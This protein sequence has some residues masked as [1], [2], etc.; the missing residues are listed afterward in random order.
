MAFT[1]N[2]GQD[3]LQPVNHQIRRV[4]AILAL[5][6]YVHEG[7]QPSSKCYNGEGKLTVPFTNLPQNQCL[8]HSTCISSRGTPLV[9]GKKKIAYR[10]ISAAQKAKKMYV[11]HS[12]LQTCN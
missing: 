3:I 7:L 4:K 12:I 10:V 6:P 8:A 5:C 9:S 11:P 2:L 1:N